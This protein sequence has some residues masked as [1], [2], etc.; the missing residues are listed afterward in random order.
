MLGWM[1]MALAV[2]A[3]GWSVVGAIVGGEG[4]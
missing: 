4:V 1:G 3:W 2:Y